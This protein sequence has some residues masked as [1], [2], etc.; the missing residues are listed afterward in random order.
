MLQRM[1]DLLFGFEVYLFFVF[2][3]IFTTVTVTKFF[4][5]TALN[6]MSQFNLEN[7]TV[8]ASQSSDARAVSLYIDCVNIKCM[9]ISTCL[10]ACV[11][12]CVCVCVW[13]GACVC[14]M[15]MHGYVFFWGFVSM[16]VCVCVCVCVCVHACYGSWYILTLYWLF[17]WG[18][19]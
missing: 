8:F 15:C 2:L 16:F 4:S 17:I 12:V 13:L 9:H 6:L 1:R 5:P 11:C 10:H 7:I 19:W 18:R 14:V 3:S